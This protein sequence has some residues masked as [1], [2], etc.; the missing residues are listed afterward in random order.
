METPETSGSSAEFESADHDSTEHEVSDEI[1]AQL[2][3]GIEIEVSADS[4]A[5]ISANNVPAEETP[6]QFYSSDAEPERQP[7]SAAE[8]P[9]YSGEHALPES[10]PS[11]EQE[12]SR[13]AAAGE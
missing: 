10:E 13:K 12:K 6:A 5:G 4:L 11:T 7:Q 2:A 8:T 3:Q 1:L 9:E